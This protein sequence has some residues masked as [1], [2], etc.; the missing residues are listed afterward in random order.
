M[1]GIGLRDKVAIDER[2]FQVHTGNDPAKNIIKSEVFEK[3][4][5]LF[6]S[7][8]AYLVREDKPDAPVNINFLKQTALEQH[9]NTLNEIRILFLVNEKIKQL[10]QHLPHYRLGKVFLNRNFV[11]EAIAN[12][13]RVVELKPEFVRGHIK[14]GLSFFKA[15]RY[16]EAIKAFLQA[17]KLNPE[18]P[19]ILN[20]LGVCYI[21]TQNYKLASKFLKN[22][23]RLKEDYKEANFNLGIVLF[24]STIEDD[25]EDDVVPVPARFIRSYKEI[26]KDS[27][28]QSINW[29]N[30]FATTQEA[31]EGGI[32]KHIVN[33]LTQIQRDIMF[34]EDSSDIMD[35]FF[36]QFMFGGSEIKERKLDLFEDMIIQEVDSHDTYADYWNELGVIHLIQCREYFLKAITEFEKANKLDPDFEAAQRNSDLLKHNKQG[37]LILL[38]AILK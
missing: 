13:L 21:Q 29:K 17:H 1:K 2:E 24:L 7:E 30:T 22:A 19:D 14:L 3:G 15:G 5:F 10:R 18:Y 25:G 28:F 34:H 32:K 26:I 38:R 36:L 11:D 9:D 37:F 27:A 16:K 6:S 35:L 8:D 4:Q 23:L 20:N 12:F 31:L 33:A